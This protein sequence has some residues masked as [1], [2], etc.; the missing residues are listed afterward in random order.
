M[1][2]QVS[3]RVWII[4]ARDSSPIWRKMPIDDMEE[5]IEVVL[6]F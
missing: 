4:L 3:N 1:S 2:L 6:H 5:G